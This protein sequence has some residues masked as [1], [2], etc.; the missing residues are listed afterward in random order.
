MANCALI[1]PSCTAS[2]ASMELAPSARE[3]GSASGMRCRG[4]R[5]RRFGGLPRQTK[6]R[7][8]AIKRGERHYRS[9]TPCRRGH[10][11]PWRRVSTG[12]CFRCERERRRAIARCAPHAYVVREMTMAAAARKIRSENLPS[13]AEIRRRKTER[14]VQAHE[15]A[16][17]PTT[18][19]PAQ[20][21][22]G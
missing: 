22:R 12:A 4:S 6:A 11:R 7:Q 8:M 14:S 2:D 17:F 9:E 5:C 18:G 15:A 1:I 16:A 19:M 21:Q 13:T 10:K 20:S 3:S